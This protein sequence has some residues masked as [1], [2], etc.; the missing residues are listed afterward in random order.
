MSRQDIGPCSLLSAN[1]L[2]PL[3]KAHE[4]IAKRLIRR[5]SPQLTEE[6]LLSEGDSHNGFVSSV[7]KPEGCPHLLKLGDYLRKNYLKGGQI[8]NRQF[9]PNNKLEELVTKKIVLL[10]LQETTIEQR[11]H[12]DL[13]LWVLQ[14]SMRL[15]LTLVL[16]TRGSAERL[17]WLQKFKQ[18]GVNDR[19]LPLGFSDDEPNYGYSMAAHPAEGAQRF[20]S[21]MD[22]RDKD[23]V[24]FEIYQWMFLAPV[25]GASNKFRHQLNREQPLPWVKLSQKPTNGI[26]GEILSAEIHPAHLDSQC[27][28]ALGLVN[29]PDVHGIPVFI[30]LVRPSDEIDAFFDINTGKFKATH[31]IIEPS[32]VHPIAAYQK[33]GDDFIV[34]RWVGDDNSFK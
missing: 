13:A 28:S 2:R 15:F 31:P 4:M 8:G 12:E 22:W 24:L 3:I 27:L 18:D 17:S 26:L 16:L 29:D 34:F 14:N 23:L 33:H 30:K 6:V 1:L 20:Y 5:K 11:Y 32:R 10:V 7:K 21:F 9:L 19:A 25:L